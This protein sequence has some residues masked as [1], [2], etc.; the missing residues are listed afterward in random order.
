[1]FLGI[2]ATLARLGGGFLCNLKWVKARLLFQASTF[3][4]AVSTMLLTLAKT[5]G[6]LVAY[7]IV[8]SAADGMM[9]VTFLIECMNC[10][11]ESKQASAIGFTLISAGVTGVGSPPLA[12]M[13]LSHPMIS[14]LVSIEIHG[15]YPTK[16]CVIR[17]CISTSNFFFIYWGG[18]LN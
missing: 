5:Y 15:V 10:V 3:I 1:M 7:S 9:M 6:S 14:L 13:R 11:E 12:G 17:L 8:F 18:A 16:S 4:M 2:F